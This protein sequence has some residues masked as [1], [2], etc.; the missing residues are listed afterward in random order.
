[1]IDNLDKEAINLP[2]PEQPT[3]KQE[4]AAEIKRS[5]ALLNI[6]RPKTSERQ[7]L[8]DNAR[9]QN[10]TF[11]RSHPVVFRNNIVICSVNNTTYIYIYRD[12]HKSLRDFRPLRY[13]SRDGHAQG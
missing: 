10:A 13:S 1:M 11:D 7:N 9:Q 2:S 8:G 5:S 4:K 12:I 3:T 6:R